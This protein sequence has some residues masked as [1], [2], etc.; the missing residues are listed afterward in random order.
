MGIFREGA[1]S[2]K[3]R[4]KLIGIWEVFRFPSCQYL[5]FGVNK[6]FV[7]RLVG[8]PFVDLVKRGIFAHTKRP[9]LKG[10]FVVL[11]VIGQS[12]NST[13]T[14]TPHRQPV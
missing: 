4:S 3:I 10:R 2:K 14:H 9:F 1:F 7:K 8:T 13:G 5:F 11:L 6:F 12:S